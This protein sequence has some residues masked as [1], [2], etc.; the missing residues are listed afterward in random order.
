MTEINLATTIA[1]KSDQL[2]AD[3]LVAG[4]LVTRV[5]NIEQK[6]SKEQPIWIHLES[7]PGRPWKPCLTQRRLLVRLWG[8][9][10]GKSYVGRTVELMCDPKVVWAGA[11]VGGIRIYALSHIEK[12]EWV[13]VSESKNKR[14]QYLVRKIDALPDTKAKQPAEPTKPRGD[15]ASALST[16]EKWSGDVAP[17]KKGLGDSSWTKEEKMQIAE[18]VKALELR[19]AEA[20]TVDVP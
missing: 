13:A 6:D 1:P 19:Q 15:I 7:H 14:T 5:V 11:N 2:N 16:I 20:R 17:L 12:E 18:A 10:A 8:D 9:G 3:D 4:R